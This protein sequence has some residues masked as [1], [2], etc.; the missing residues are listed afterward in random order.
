MFYSTT[1]AACSS[2]VEFNTPAWLSLRGNATVKVP[3]PVCRGTNIL[4]IWTGCPATVKIEARETSI[5]ARHMGGDAG[6]SLITWI[7]EVVGPRTARGV[8]S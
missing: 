8:R 4:C 2:V 3:C 1:C 5:T 6:N 7:D